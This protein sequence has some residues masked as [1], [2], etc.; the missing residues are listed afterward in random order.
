MVLDGRGGAFV[1][2]HQLEM[3]VALGA[4]DAATRG[5]RIMGGGRSM[6]G[7]AAPGIRNITGR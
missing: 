7:G 3:Q 1:D 2:S 5:G 4:N 6:K